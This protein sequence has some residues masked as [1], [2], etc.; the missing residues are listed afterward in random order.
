MQQVKESRYIK[1]HRLAN[2]TYVDIAYA[3]FG[4]KGAA[5]VYFVTVFCLEG[6]CSVY[7]NFVSTT[8]YSIYPAF[9]QQQYLL[10]TLFFAVVMTMLN[11]MTF[12]K[13]MSGLGIIAVT[14]TI[15]CVMWYSYDNFSFAEIGEYEL[16]RPATYFRSFGSIAFFFCVNVNAMPIEREMKTRTQWGQ[17]VLWTCL[18][19][20]IINVFYGASVFM[21][22]RDSTCGN[23]VMNL[24]GGAGGT[25]AW[26]IVIPKITMI[27]ELIV[28]YPLILY[29]AV[30]IVL[31]SF[32]LHKDNPS[33]SRIFSTKNGVTFVMAALPALF[34]QVRSFAVLVNLVGGFAAALS[35]Y[36]FPPLLFLKVCGKDFQTSEGK[37]IGC[38]CLAAVG[39]AMSLITTW[40]T[41]D[42]MWHPFPEP[43]FC[44]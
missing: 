44:K 9:T 13:Y 37:I 28:S 43:A 14:F 38:V 17:V 7:L 29:A 40:Y 5:F 35:A 11:S 24:N 30:D 1:E 33:S 20:A 34:A 6:V 22:L 8:A 12:L 26:L 39:L 32:G 42:G 27:I 36:C 4:A 31:R 25:A 15:C 21:L 10:F 23:V 41:I 16:F 19:L 2:E 18:S 3:G